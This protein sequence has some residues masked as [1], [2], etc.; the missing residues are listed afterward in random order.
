MYRS[1]N[2]QPWNY[3]ILDAHANVKDLGI[4]MH[5]ALFFKGYEW[6]I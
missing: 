1:S 6:M 4:K 3:D 2:E 5:F